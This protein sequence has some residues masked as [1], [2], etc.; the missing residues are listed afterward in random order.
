MSRAFTTI[1]EPKQQPDHGDLLE[2]GTFPLDA[3]PEGMRT[4]AASLADVHQIDV[5]LPAMAALATLSGAIG[6]SVTVSGAVNGRDTHCNLF[7]IAGAPKSYGKGAASTAAKPIVEA[8]ADVLEQFMQNERADLQTEVELLEG[9]KKKQLKECGA[10]L[11]EFGE[12]DKT[13]LSET[14]AKLEQITWLLE[15]KARPGFHVGA[16]TGA[17]LEEHLSR[18][19][20]TAF[21]FSPEAG[22]M[23]RIALGKYSKDGSGDF[24]LFLSGYSVE[25]YS[26]GRV[27]RGFKSL[28]PCLSSLWMCQPSLLRELY[29]STEGLERGLTARVLAFCCEHETIPEDDGI[30]REVDRAAFETWDHLI[31]NILENR[32]SPQI[33]QTDPAAREAFLQWHNE[34]VKLRNGLLRDVEGEAGRWRE[35]AIRIAGVLAVAA[36]AERITERIAADAIRLC[37][38]AVFSGLSLL[39]SGRTARQSEQRIKLLLILE[40]GP[41]TARDL[42]RRHGVSKSTIRHLITVCPDDFILET[43]KPEG[44]GRPSEVVRL[45]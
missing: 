1:E 24:D 40:A 31:R 44:A 12:C 32:K 20:E 22:D 41:V 34:S 5:A 45:K 35:N 10:M 3:L 8:S 14:N 21:S 39:A 43:I 26:S 15:T 38:W 25:S 7:I 2:P 11:E 30:L 33:L 42:H 13:K 27:G 29:G 23:V 6:K 37:R 4:V 28:T 18:N 17:A 16:C 19:D 36:G 9:Q